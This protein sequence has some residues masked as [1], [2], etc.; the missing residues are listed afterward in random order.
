MIL[1]SLLLASCFE[2]EAGLTIY[3]D[4]YPSKFSVVSSIAPSSRSLSRGH[5]PFPRVGSFE[6]LVTYTSENII[7]RGGDNRRT[8]R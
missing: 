8:G 5:T 6:L 2:A 3:L 1:A 4:Q 7:H